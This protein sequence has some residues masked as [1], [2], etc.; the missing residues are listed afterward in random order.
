M[1]ADAAGRRRFLECVPTHREIYDSQKL[2]H[3]VM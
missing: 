3:Y 1:I 2:L